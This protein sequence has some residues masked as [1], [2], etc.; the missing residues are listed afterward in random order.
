MTMTQQ[1]SEGYRFFHP[2]RTIPRLQ[3]QILDFLIIPY[4]S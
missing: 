2:I 4:F 1:S 3:N